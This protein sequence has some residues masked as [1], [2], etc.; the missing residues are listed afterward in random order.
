M[1]D[2]QIFSNPEFG[3][4]ATA[5]IT[6]KGIRI[7]EG[8]C[9]CDDMLFHQGARVTVNIYSERFEIKLENHVWRFSRSLK[10]QKPNHFPR[11]ALLEHQTSDSLIHQKF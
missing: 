9:F 11:Y 10:E 3:N 1:N 6:R 4:T 8:Y 7:G 5:V 2:L